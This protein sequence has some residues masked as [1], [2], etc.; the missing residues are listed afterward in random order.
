MS[1][2]QAPQ[3]GSITWRDLT[4]PDATKV[5]D[6]YKE[7][8]GWKVEPVSMG[9]YNDYNVNT[10]KEGETV[11]GICHARGENSKMPAQWL[12]Y[13]TV[14]NVEESARKCTEHGGEILD[15]PRDLGEGR[16]CV[17]KDPAGAVCAL[18]APTS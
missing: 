12:M 11:A 14:A 16:F 17:V 15:G 8:V 1:E 13:I 3:V 5:A 2:D 6:F 18:Y 10:P 9:D 4:V 7:V